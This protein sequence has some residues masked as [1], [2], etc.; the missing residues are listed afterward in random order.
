[1]P[2]ADATAELIYSNLMLQWCDRPEQLFAE[3][4]R[5][6]RP[7]GLLLFSSFGPESLAE[8]RAAWMQADGH[9]HVSEFPDMPELASALT[10]AGFVEPVLDL[11]AVRRDYPDALSLMRE[12][13]QLGAH[14]AARERSRGLTGRARLAA[15]T[16]AYEQRRTPAGL[17]ATFQLLYGAAFKGTSGPGSRDAE[18]GTQGEFVVPL[19]RV[20][21][22]SP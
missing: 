7:G 13:K 15:M 21:R 4:A 18:T 10:H 20:R 14:N 5:V 2:L 17:P 6:L 12:L 22:R 19:A 16:Q 1:L 3:C 9:L 11:D 8:L